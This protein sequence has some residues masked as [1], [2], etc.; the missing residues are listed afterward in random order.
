MFVPDPISQWESK[1]RVNLKKYHPVTNDPQSG[2]RF[3]LWLAFQFFIFLKLHA[4]LSS[5]QHELGVRATDQRQIGCVLHF[6]FILFCA[7]QFFCRV[8]P[9]QMPRIPYSIHMPKQKP[10]WEKTQSSVHRASFAA[11]QSFIRFSCVFENTYF[12]I[13]IMSACT[14]TDKTHKK[15]GYQLDCSKITDLKWETHANV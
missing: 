3:N 13:S 15:I 8:I 2:S 4:G 7:Q 9:K 10:N 1:E 5:S 12:F 14:W 6:L 11:V